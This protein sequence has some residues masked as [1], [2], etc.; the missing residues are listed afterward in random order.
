MKRMFFTGLLIG[1]DEA[2]QPSPQFKGAGWD[3]TFIKE[4]RDLS[5]L[6]NARVV[7]I[8]AKSWHRA[9]YALNLVLSS[10]LLYSG[11][12][13]F[14]EM[15]LVAYND[16][17]PEFNNPLYRK[18]VTKRYMGTV[19]IPIACAIAA[20]VSRKR[21]WVYAL[22]KY[23]FSIC[24][25]GMF[26]ADLEPFRSPYL[27]VSPFPEDHIKFSQ[28]IVSAYSGIEDLGLEIR[29]S[30]KR[31]SRING[32]WNTPVRRDLEDRLESASIDLNDTTLWTIRGPKRKIEK[33]RT[34]PSFEKASWAGGA[35]RDA[36]IEM[37][38]AIA[39][40]GWL[41]DCVASHSVKELTKVLS[42]YDVVNV[43]HLARRLILETIGYWRY[44][45]KHAAF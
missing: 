9:Q 32:K 1:P 25:Y 38:D 8:S 10:I 4:K 29:A 24:L 39:Y 41:R 26:S 20:K 11:E 30:E 43:Q 13:P 22:T 12:P 44:Y 36:E 27:S 3:V 7:V 6:E 14:S 16:D 40:S 18:A 31:P 33:K 35:V 17:E 45:E 21:K 5:K 2:G 34:I 23:K 15:N 37:V 19:D 42:P 28:A